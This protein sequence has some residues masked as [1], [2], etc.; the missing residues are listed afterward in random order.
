MP[1]TAQLRSPTD[2]GLFI[3][4]RYSHSQKKQPATD[5]AVSVSA[6]R[7]KR[8]Q[9]NSSAGSMAMITSSMMERV[10]SWPRMWGEDV[11]MSLRFL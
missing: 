6:R 2:W 1:V 7:P 4:L 5:T 8:I 9:A 10:V 11:A 3:S